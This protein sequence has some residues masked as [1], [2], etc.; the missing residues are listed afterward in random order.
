MNARGMSYEALDKA[1]QKYVIYIFGETS[2]PSREEEIWSVEE[3]FTR[4][5]MHAK[6]Q[7]EFFLNQRAAESLDRYRRRRPPGGCF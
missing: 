1:K 5:W 4:G 3:Q 6:V 2:P 7:E